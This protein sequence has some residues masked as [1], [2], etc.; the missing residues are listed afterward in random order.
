M[1]QTQTFLSYRLHNHQ[2]AQPPTTYIHIL[3]VLVVYALTFAFVVHATN[4]D[5]F[6][7]SVA[8]PPSCTTTYHI[9]TYFR[10]TG[11]LCVDLCL[12]S[13]C[14]KLRPFYPIGCTTTKLHNHL[15]HTYIF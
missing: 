10:R 14:H 12:R 11:R 13:P 7:L 4:S 15:P 3:G 1:P 9:H 5:L 2:V 8:Q 6:I